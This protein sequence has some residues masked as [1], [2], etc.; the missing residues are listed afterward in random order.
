LKWNS[1]QHLLIS[2]GNDNRVN[3]FD[4]RKMEKAIQTLHYHKAA[5][6]SI[7]FWNKK[8]GVIVTGSGHND[9][10]LVLHSTLLN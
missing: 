4:D 7:D 2:G 5:I 3:I 1:E 6:R 9:P 10:S 8:R